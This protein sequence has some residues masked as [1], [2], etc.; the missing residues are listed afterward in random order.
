M[1]LT[2]LM[3]CLNEA[4]T[5]ARCIEKAKLGLQRA[6][7][8]GEIVIAD[9]G[10]TD[11]SQVIAE[12]AG[13]RLVPV[14]EKGYG[15]ALIG[16]V[17]AAAGEWIIMG[18][19]DDSY[20]FSDIAGFVKKFREGFE[21][22]M[23]CRLPAGGGT[24][25][26]GAMPWKNRWL[27]NPTLSFIGRLFFKC[28]AHDFHAGLRG[29]TKTAFEKMDLQ[30]TGMEFASEMVIKSTL[31]GLKISEVPITLH[32]DGRSRPPH[33][34]PWR[35]GWRHLR[36]MLLFSPRWLFLMPGIFLSLLGIVFAARLSFGNFQ[37][38]GI[39]FNVGTLAVACM[40][41]IIGCQLVAFAFFVKVFAI[42]EGLLPD[43]PKLTRVFKIFTLE[44]GIVVGLLVL[45]GGIFLLA[46]SVWIWRMNHYG[47]LD[48]SEN[49]RRLIPAATL[50]VL[51]IQGIFSSFFMSTL[52]LKTK[53]RR[54]PAVS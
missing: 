1:E 44:K 8:R 36:F 24:I 19:A 3:P 50:V 10:S 26:P 6:G 14:H 45:L 34:K 28:P 27:G 4:E 2:I 51:G 31:K 22:V 41:I 15:S 53:T 37:L 32:K 52:G 13:V 46:Q 39:L 47:L 12:K 16:G 30:T 17:R 29:F 35:D 7:V 42:A 43:D 21:L 20:D 18:D 5:L 49:L 33:L 48:P 11:G 25:A 23:G 9:N 38:G 54:P 40:T